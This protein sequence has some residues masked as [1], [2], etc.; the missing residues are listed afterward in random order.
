MGDRHLAGDWV[1]FLSVAASDHPET[2]VSNADDPEWIK[3]LVAKALL[4][5]ASEPATPDVPAMT[6]SVSGAPNPGSETPAVRPAATWPEMQP[7]D[8]SSFAKE[9]QAASTPPPSTPVTSPPPVA[10]PPVPTPPPV[11]PPPVPT[12]PPVAHVAPPVE[13]APAS[14]PAPVPDALLDSIAARRHDHVAVPAP[15]TQSLVPTGGVRPSEVAV[16]AGPQ[17]ALTGTAD[18]DHVMVETAATTEGF[19]SSDIRTVLEWLA[20]IVSALIV[21]LVI[22][23]LVLQAFW[24]PS[25]S[26]QTTVNE[27]DRILVNKVS[28]RLHE[29]RRGDLVV[30][31]KLEGTP[32]DTKDLI[33]RAIALPG[34]TIE[35]RSD[36]R[37]WIWGP[38]ET[39]DDAK[40]LE[41]PYLDPQNAVLNAPSAS[42]PL[43][44][45]VWDE[46]CVNQPRTPGRCQL[47]DSSYFMM[48]DNRGRSSDSRFFGPVP[49]ENVVGRAFLRIWPL[50]DISTL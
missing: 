26:M 31:E 10:P 5:A 27:G 49:D 22:K 9:R 43:T 37:I 19:R 40:L 8:T 50:G 45:D 21:A 39:P 32:G 48:G 15:T 7:L 4:H 17:D 44:A 36:G 3:G 1:R 14:A 2:P 13:S 46:N 25:E 41:E 34:E 30:F 29:V 20:V 23:A 11:A 12:P 28:Y 38:G 18:T 33:K 6:P 24:I 42:D 35:I 16:S 47:D